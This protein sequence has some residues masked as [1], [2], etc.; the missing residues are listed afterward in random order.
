MTDTYLRTLERRFRSSGAVED[1]A[2]WL[3]ERV[4]LGDLTRQRVEL[5][6]FCDHSG[7]RAALGV[8]SPPRLGSLARVNERPELLVPF[9]HFGR[10]VVL[11]LLL[12][13]GWASEGLD[14]AGRSMLCRSFAAIET[15]LIAGLASEEAN[16]IFQQFSAHSSRRPSPTFDAVRRMASLLVIQSDVQAANTAWP[17][18]ARLTR[19]RTLGIGNDI[20]RELIPWALKYG[21]PVEARVSKRRS[22][23]TNSGPVIPGLRG[24]GGTACDG[25][26]LGG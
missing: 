3:H 2:A 1:E 13:L 20:A 6:A 17:A 5:A 4:R 18:V 16:R 14:R 10:E 8:E 7:S 12:A 26:G 19:G 21:D 23:R 22:A 11:R 9:A 25:R 15:G 24:P